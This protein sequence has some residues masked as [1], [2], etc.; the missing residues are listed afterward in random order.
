MS[1]SLQADEGTESIAQ[2]FANFQHLMELLGPERIYTKE[3]MEAFA[4]ALGKNKGTKFRA[5]WAGYWCL[6]KN[7]SPHFD[8]TSG[9]EQVTSDKESKLIAARRLEKLK[10]KSTQKRRTEKQASGGSELSGHQNPSVDLLR[11]ESVQMIPYEEEDVARHM[12]MGVKNAFRFRNRYWIMNALCQSV[13]TTIANHVKQLPHTK[14]IVYL[15]LGSPTIKES[16]ESAWASDMYSYFAAVDIVCHL[17]TLHLSHEPVE[18]IC[19]DDCFSDEDNRMLG[20]YLGHT[21]KVV[22]SP[23]EFLEIDANMLVVFND[24][25]T[26]YCE[27]VADLTHP[28][29]VPRAIIGPIVYTKKDFFKVMDPNNMATPR[30]VEFL[31]GYKC[32]SFEGIHSPESVDQ[33]P[34]AMTWLRHSHIYLKCR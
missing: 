26:P 16:W 15:G 18:I 5:E 21:I 1:T 23:Q 10:T 24:R 29:H 31:Q 33:H 4:K 22:E 9:R 30:V 25:T 32:I 34:D 13:G 20:N 11:R 3:L 12:S 7:C 8:E 6:S 28:F 17:D 14:K 2:G 19:Q 27:I